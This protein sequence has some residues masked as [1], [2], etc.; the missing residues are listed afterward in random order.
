MTARGEQNAELMD[1]WLDLCEAANKLRPGAY[2]RW[3]FAVGLQGSLEERINLGL[4]AL[5]R[6]L[7]HGSTGVVYR[8]RPV[9]KKPA[10]LAKAVR[11]TARWI[12]GTITGSLITLDKAG[13]EQ[14]A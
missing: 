14:D 4:V 9:P 5:E 1:A 2:E 11:R 13:S 7:N 10:D 8:L 12:G 6:I 3:K